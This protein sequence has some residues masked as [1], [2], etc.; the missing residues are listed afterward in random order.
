MFQFNHGRI[1][2][3]NQPVLSNEG[4][5]TCQWKAWTHDW[6]LARQPIDYKTEAITTALRPHFYYIF[7]KLKMS[8]ASLIKA[9]KQTNACM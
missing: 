6:Q 1:Y 5:F 9:K 4:K 7:S 3:W 2:S 8:L